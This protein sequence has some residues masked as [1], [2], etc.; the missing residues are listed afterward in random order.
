MAQNTDLQNIAFMPYQD[1]F[2]IDLTHMWRDSFE[3]ALNIHDPNPIIEQQNY[4]L[5]EVLPSHK[6]QLAVNKLNGQIAGFIAANKTCVS[7]LYIHHAYHRCG[8]GSHFVDWAK[9]QSNNSLCAYTF[10]KNWIA[11]NFYEKHGFKATEKGF[12][13]TWQLEDIRYEWNQYN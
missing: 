11:R 7:Q 12:E 1:D 10:E 3:R 6:V 5:S 2:L 4:F 9:G 13:P 8:I